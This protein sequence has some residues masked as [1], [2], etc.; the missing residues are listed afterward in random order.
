MKTLTN[1][2]I[3]LLLALLYQVTPLRCV[4][5]HAIDINSLSVQIDDITYSF[6][7]NVMGNIENKDNG[8]VR[9]SIGLGDPI[10]KVKLYI[11]AEVKDWDQIHDI[12]L[13]TRSDSMMMVF[14]NTKYSFTIMPSIQYAT[15]SG[16]QYTRKL[17]RRKQAPLF[18][19][20]TPDWT[21]MS[22]DERQATGKGIIR[23]KGMEQTGLFL[24]LSP[25]TEN[26]QLK[27]IIGNFSGIAA[28]NPDQSVSS[29]TITIKEGQFRIE[30]KP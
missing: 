26:G 3:G 25:V 9:V 10:Q 11:S 29:D 17:N 16:E 8:M 12:A 22:Q 23:N 24:S 19:K 28:K 20:E 1:V 18:V 30:V 7:D 21:R 5:S 6:K 14:R 13:S 4:T 2:T 27:E 15:Y